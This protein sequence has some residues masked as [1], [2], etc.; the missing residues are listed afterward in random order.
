MRS[1][2]I[3]EWTPIVGKIEKLMSLSGSMNAICITGTMES[4]H[5]LQFTGGNIRVVVRMP[6]R[7]RHDSSPGNAGEGNPVE[8]LF[9][10]CSRHVVPGC[11]HPTDDRQIRL[12]LPEAGGRAG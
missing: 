12:L 5:L 9:R 2:L 3:S 11:A 7:G 10:P 6:A 1:W 4:K 8:Q